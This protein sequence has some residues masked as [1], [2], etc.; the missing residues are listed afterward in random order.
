VSSSFEDG[1]TD[2]AIDG[3]TDG[4]ALSTLSIVFGPSVDED[5]TFFFEVL[6]RTRVFVGRATV[7]VLL[8]QGIL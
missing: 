2:G 6:F 5:A 7:S 8:I 3:S 1:S 4:L